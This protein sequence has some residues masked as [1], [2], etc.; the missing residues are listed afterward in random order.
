MYKDLPE[1][2]VIGVTDFKSR[3]LAVIDNVARGK[4]TRAVLTKRG[5]PIAAIVSLA[6]DPVELWGALKGSVQISPGVDLTEGLGE[7]WE[8]DV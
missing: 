7:V 8:A 1:Q 3:C 4:T 6:H 5:K 2:T